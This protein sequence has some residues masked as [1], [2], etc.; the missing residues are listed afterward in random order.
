MRSFN[1]SPKSRLRCS[2]A[3]APYWWVE[4]VPEGDNG[5]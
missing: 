5:L 2:T 3:M 1:P 4:I